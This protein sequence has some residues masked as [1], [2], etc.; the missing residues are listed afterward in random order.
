V[1]GRVAVVTGAGS[2]MGRATAAL[3]AAEGAAVACWDVDVEGA[4]DTAV[5]ISGAG[6]RA[7][8]VVADISDEAAVAGAV[9][10]THEALGAVDL[11]VNNAG[12]SLLT[13]L[14]APDWRAGWDRTLAVN[15]TG[16][17]LVLR[18]CTEDLRRSDAARVVNVASTEGLGA[19]PYL[20]AYTVAKH[21]VI[22]LT[23]SAAVELARDRVTVNCVCP[24]PIR[25]AMT[26]AIAADQQERF[27]RRRVPMRRYG[28]PE[29]VADVI[30]SL[31]LPSATYVTGA[32]VTV[33]GGLTVQ[34]T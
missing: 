31:L 34:N 3:L 7:V 17:A 10:A 25:T 2:G 8:A 22:G 5:R 23:R 4:H 30:V 21:G 29:E 6:G 27:A 18:A 28:D 20:S 33:D 13:P 15:L 1:A 16:P 12:I 24:G 19:T 32:V 26:A 9:A 11:L 14:D